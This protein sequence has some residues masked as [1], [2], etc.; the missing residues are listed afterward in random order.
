MERCR[1]YIGAYAVK[2][3]GRVD[4]IVFCGGIGERDADCRRRICAD[5]EGLWGVKSTTRR[6]NLRSMVH[7]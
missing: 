7:Q 3:K 5:L 4:A 2:L 1:K 6:I